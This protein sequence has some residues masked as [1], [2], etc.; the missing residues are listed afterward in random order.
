VG[1]V[2]SSEVSRG[3]ECVLLARLVQLPAVDR[4]AWLAGE[5]AVCVCASEMCVLLGC[6]G[7]GGGG[8]GGG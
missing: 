8:G 5:E 6:W 7:R 2:V 4:R 1:C 3:E